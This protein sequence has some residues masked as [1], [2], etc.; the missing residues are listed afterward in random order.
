M[1]VDF[2]RQWLFQ[3]KNI[4]PTKWTGAGGKNVTDEGLLNQI[5]EERDIRS[6]GGVPA[7]V[8]PAILPRRAQPEVGRWL[9]C[10]FGHS[11]PFSH[12]YLYHH[13][14]LS[15]KKIALVYS[16]SSVTRLVPGYVY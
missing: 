3:V 16:R 7:G 10:P 4:K 6:S 14:N 1:D 15:V 13:G 9:P 5:P 2:Y 11:C 12:H 8:E